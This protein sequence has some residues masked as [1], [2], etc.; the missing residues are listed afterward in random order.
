MSARVY[1]HENTARGRIRHGNSTVPVP[2]DLRL[3]LAHAFPTVPRLVKAISVSPAT[4]EALLSPG[5]VV[6]AKVL[7]R[8]R[9]LAERVA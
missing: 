6:R 1:I 9:E 4:A 3:K 8:V 5:G 7:E 2:T